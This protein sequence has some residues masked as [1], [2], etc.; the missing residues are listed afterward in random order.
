MLKLDID[1]IYLKK[2]IV[3]IIFELSLEKKVK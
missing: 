3:N 2:Y 1:Q